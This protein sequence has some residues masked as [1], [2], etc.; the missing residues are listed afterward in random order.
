VEWDKLG[1]VVVRHD[2]ITIF[3]KDRKYLQYQVMQSLSDLE[4]AQITGFC[5]EQMATKET[6]NVNINSN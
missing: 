2:F 6:N 4:I 1:D 3:H 5:K